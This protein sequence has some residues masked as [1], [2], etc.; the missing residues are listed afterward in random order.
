V[1]ISDA[2]VFLSLDYMKGRDFLR[3]LIV[4]EQFKKRPNFL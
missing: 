3:K 4:A 1:S 2:F